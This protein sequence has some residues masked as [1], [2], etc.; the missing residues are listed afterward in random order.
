MTL[1]TL[2][3]AHL[4]ADYPLQGDFLASTKGKNIISLVSH[5]G[6]WTGTIL[7]A[8]HL[9]GYGVN[10]VDV[11]ILF[12]VHAGA[13]YMKARPVGI[14]KRLDALKG[15]LMLDQSIHLLQILILMT[16]KGMF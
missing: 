15:G 1:L 4:I 3:F 5:A 12:I 6:I 9:L 8:G 2:I 14:Y 16:Y 7:I 13:D 11:A 10:V